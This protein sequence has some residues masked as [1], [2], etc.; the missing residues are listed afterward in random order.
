MN[1]AV[2][3]DRDGTINVNVHYLDKPENLH[4][5]DGVSEGIRLLKKNDFKII[6]ITNQSGIGRGFFSEDVLEKIH[7]KLVSELNKNGAEIDAIYYCPHHPEEN[8]TCRKPN[9]DLMKKA[10][11]DF[12][13]DIKRSYFIGDRM[14]DVET[15]FNVGCKTV[16]VPENK[17][18]IRK[19]MEKSSI[20]PNHINDTFYLAVQW[21]LKNSKNGG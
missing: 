9:T 7:E 3:I 18:K 8:C 13:I 10:I 20:K 16:L 14:L 1:K 12:D 11:M 2:F 15:G 5:Y 21:I 17:E 19:E 6:I 4:I